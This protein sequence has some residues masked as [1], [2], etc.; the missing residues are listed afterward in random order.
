MYGFLKYQVAEYL[1]T[2]LRLGWHI[3]ATAMG[4]AYKWTEPGPRGRVF[5]RVN[6]TIEIRGNWR[7]NNGLEAFRAMDPLLNHL[8]DYPYDFGYL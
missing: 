5:T 3:E 4:P 2:P 1:M 8:G 7:L 6:L